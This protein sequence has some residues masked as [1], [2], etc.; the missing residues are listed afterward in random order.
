ML[1]RYSNTN[2]QKYYFDDVYVGDI[3][4]DL[5]PPEVLQLNVTGAQNLELVFS[6][7]VLSL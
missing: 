4:V 1:V 6:E 2:R 5:T 7:A 3:I